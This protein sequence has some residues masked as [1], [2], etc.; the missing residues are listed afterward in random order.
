MTHNG[1]RKSP[2]DLHIPDIPDILDR[3]LAHDFSPT[4]SVRAPGLPQ[5]QQIQLVAMT[6]PSQAHCVGS[7][8]LP[9]AH[10]HE[11]GTYTTKC[12]LKAFY[13]HILARP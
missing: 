1:S 11:S 12:N 7:L 4:A 6:F 3:S 2:Q 8:D 9:R 13:T 5:R 10:T